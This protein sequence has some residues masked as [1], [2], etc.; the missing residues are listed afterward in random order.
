MCRFNAQNKEVRFGNF[1]FGPIVMRM[2]YY[3][4]EDEKAL[5]VRYQS[6]HF[7]PNSY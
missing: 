2:F 1:I 4:Q 3:L 5:E 7:I 6:R